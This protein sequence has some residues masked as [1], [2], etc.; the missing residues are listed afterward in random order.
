MRSYLRRQAILERQKHVFEDV[1][2]V[3]YAFYAHIADYSFLNILLHKFNM[4]MMLLDS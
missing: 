4:H 3:A 2:W 1:R